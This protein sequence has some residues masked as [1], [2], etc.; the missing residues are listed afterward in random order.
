[1]IPATLDAVFQEFENRTNMEKSLPAGNPN[2][3]YRLDRMRRLCAAFDNP[4]DSVPSIHIAG[5]KGKGSTGAFIGA[6]LSAQGF[7]TGVYSSPHLINYRER[8]CI[9]GLPF[10]ENEALECAGE[11]LQKL[12]DV[13]KDLR[14]ERHASTF[15]LLTLLA[16]VLF[17]R[18]G[19]QRMVIETGLGGR[20]DA[21]N[22]IRSPLAVILTP[23][24]L[25]H[26]DILGSR[27]SSIAREKAGI[28]K[29]GVPV[30]SARQKGPVRRVLRRNAAVKELPLT[31]LS[32]RLKQIRPLPGNSAPAGDSRP[33][34]FSWELHWKNAPPET[35][36]LAMGGRIQAENAALALA[37]VRETSSREFLMRQ[38][39]EALRQ[40][41]LPGRFHF[42]RLNPLILI[43][44]A[45]TP[46]SVEELS[47]AFAPLAGKNPLLL[48]GSVLGKD[49]LAM[50]RRLCGKTSSIFKDVI[51]ST[52]GTFKPS[53]PEEVAAS[54]RRCNTAT[55]LIPDPAEAF[56]KALEM[57]GEHRSILICGSFYMAGAVA[58]L[59]ANDL[60]IASQPS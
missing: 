2:R 56:R 60:A 45:H 44:G 24:E 32:S 11:I 25:E 43:D 42:L 20:L 22:V 58:E 59:A 36:H 49:H 41:T 34:L 9:C 3:V 15:E 17:R 50:A 48:F 52:P 39:A 19:C 7:K 16:F 47:K 31:F 1:M 26:T 57:A 54:F 8:F 10:P 28:M 12:P 35:V 38:P 21:T 29:R 53:R 23:I 14:G 51:V 33:P 4:Q 55:L 6:L 18:C 5:S 37:A 27:I 30:W 40:L 13:E 46:R